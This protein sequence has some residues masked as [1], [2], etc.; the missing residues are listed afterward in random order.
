MVLIAVGI[1]WYVYQARF[2]HG[3]SQFTAEFGHYLQEFQRDPAAAQ[4]FLLAQYDNQSVD[5]QRALQLVGYRPA[6]ADGLPDGYSMESMHV[7]KMPCCTC[8]QCLYKRSDGS[9]IA[10]FEHD[11]DAMDEWFGDR[12]ERS[13]ICGGK[14]CG[15]VDLDSRIAVSW[16]QG[17]RHIMVI[18]L[19]DVEEV[20]QLVAWFDDRS[21]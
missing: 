15:L 4:Q 18:G 1:G 19:Q 6:V 2:Q 10:I 12:P 7:M 5:P 11:D 8:V 9:T 14:R 17:K 20:N 13:A 21:L 3:D 16:K